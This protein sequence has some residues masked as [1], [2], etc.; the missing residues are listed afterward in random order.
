MTRLRDLL[1]DA[2]TVARPYWV[3]EDRGTASRLLLVVV[4]LNLGMV[5]INVLLNRWNNTF[6][7]ALQD[8]NYAIFV[9][10]VVLFSVL[11]GA[12][13]VVA[14][15]ELYLNQML[16]IH[17]RR[18]L[19]QRYLRAWLTDG[20]YYRMR[21][22]A[23]DTDNPD[24]RIAE[25][26]R[27]FIGGTL[28]LAIGGMRAV[29]TLVSFVVI[30][31]RL[32]G[33]L[34]I[35]LGVSAI[36]LPGYMVW[37]A[38][39]YAIVG[40]WLTDRI[41]R[42]LVRLSFD[43]QRYEAD[44]R[45]GLVRFRENA[46]GV[47]LYHGEADELRG[48]GERFA[49]V[50]RNWWGIMRQQKRLTWFT[51]GYGQAAVIFP[52]VVAGPRFFTGA[53]PLGGLVQTATAFGQVQ[54]SL[55]FIVTS[56]TDIAGWRSVV[57]RLAGFG[58]AFEHVRMQAATGGGIQRVGGDEA[59]VAVTGLE[60]DL[61][62]GQPLVAGVNL[63]LAR[64]ETAVLWGPSGTGK[65]TL[66]RAIAGI[67]PFGRGEIRV[68]RDARVLVLAQKPYLPIGT[69]R[70]VVSYP[71]PAGG[72][73]DATLRETLEAVDLPAL[74][75]RLDEAAHWEH[76]LSPGEQQRIAFAR[77]FVQKPDWLFLDEATSAVDEPTEARLYR[78]VRER[79]AM[80]TVFSVSHRSTL[81]SFH[82]RQFVLRPDG[83]GPASI[84]E[85]AARP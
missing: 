72:V 64:G 46:E 65:S 53:I 31:W 80:T 56:Y 16:Q 8:K 42:P 35:H 71:M 59:R 63:S 77:A 24:Q 69:L 47:A 33:P 68:P 13:M 27:L 40:T 10:Q 18:W 37:A 2:W 1:R 29:V 73:D 84:V 23:S 54:E 74:A 32:S 12:Y 81:R 60:L 70:D 25:D 9:H 38:L 48:L 66:V 28:T 67:W 21:F 4:A 61:P 76:Q 49:A 15:Y 57:N 22:G 45:F 39:V 79:L 30:L 17:W 75:G 58:R 83:N 43:Q 50:V 26:V 3:S 34:T 55:S 78:L 19:T 52:F 51:A 6:Y 85:A 5:Y 36:A 62:D 82:A 7:N 20:A 41:G 11:A 14:V 44:F